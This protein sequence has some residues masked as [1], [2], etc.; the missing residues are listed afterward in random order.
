MP[1]A[2][3]DFLDD[4][5]RK[6]PDKVAFIGEKESVSFSKLQE[7]SYRIALPIVKFGY[8]KAPIA[9]YLDRTISSIAAMHAVAYSGNFYSMIDVAMPVPRINQIFETLEPVL[10]ITDKKHFANSKEFY[11]IERTIIVDMLPNFEP[12][13][14][15][16]I[17]KAREAVLETDVLYV[18][19]TSG[20]TGIPKGVVTP[21]RAV[22]NYIIS[23]TDAYEVTESTVMGN[24]I[25]FYFVMSVLDIYGA[26]ARKALTY[27]IPKRCFM[28]PGTLVKYLAENHI[29]FIS[30]VPSALCLIANTNAFTAGDLSA[31][32]TIIFGG[33]VMPIKQLKAWQK[34]SPNATFINGYGSTEITDG[35]TFYKVD[36]EFRDDETLPIGIPFSNSNII[37]IDDNGNP[38]DSGIGELCIR[39][40]SMTYGYYKDPQKT[41]EV[42]IQNPA[43]KCFP[44]IVYR[45]GDLVK[46]NK[47]GELEYVGR[48][49]NQIKHMGRRIELGEIEANINGIC[50][51]VE[52]CCA[53]DK[54]RQQIV[55]FYTG[56]IMENELLSEIQ[57][58]LP[59]YMQPKRRIRY[60]NLPHNQNGKIDRKK[61]VEII[62]DMEE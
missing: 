14:L 26:I 45:M 23:L 22:I 50:G 49:D 9:I 44:E 25:P 33:E 62:N 27:L 34:A 17:R 6:S 48:K 38:I 11:S 36:R 8:K 16:V 55:L 61:L 39:S 60:N 5:V 7:E 13:D 28:F 12:T 51:I 19:F 18:L 3:T 59:D 31:L 10:L 4:A 41:A 20:S 32:K 46:F 24:Q 29:N 58:R 37:V 30:W 52:A 53:Y 42:Y 40:D 47:Y 35:C 15:E 2:I 21:H 54:K 43:N 56:S 1:R 57:R